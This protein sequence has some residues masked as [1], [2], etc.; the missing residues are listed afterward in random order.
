MGLKVVDLLYKHMKLQS[1]SE[2]LFEVA[3]CFLIKTQ[4]TFFLFFL[5]IYRILL[6][7]EQCNNCLNICFVSSNFC[8]GVFLLLESFTVPNVIL[9]KERLK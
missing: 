5:R 8:H 1:I 4:I 7:T 3:V 9:L 2:R 6:P